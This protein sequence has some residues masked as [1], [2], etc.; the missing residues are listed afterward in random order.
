MKETRIIGVDRLKSNLFDKVKERKIIEN[1]IEGEWIEE[2]VKDVKNMTEMHFGELEPLDIDQSER[3]NILNSFSTD[4]LIYGFAP[5]DEFGEEVI[6]GIKQ[7]WPW[8][9]IGTITFEEAIE[10]L[11][12]FLKPVLKEEVT[13]NQLK[14]ECYEHCVS[15]DEYGAITY[16]KDN[17]KWGK[18]L[19]KS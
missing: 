14:A 6:F 13:L 1:Y 17:I 15:E 16:Y 7:I 11:Y 19:W 2:A 5:I 8:E 3:E 18:E 9:K 10:R 12:K 4:N